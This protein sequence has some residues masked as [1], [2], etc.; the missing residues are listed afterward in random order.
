MSK[1]SYSKHD[2]RHYFDSVK[3]LKKSA[4]AAAYTTSRTPLAPFSSPRAK[5]PR[6]Y[7]FTDS[8]KYDFSGLTHAHADVHAGSHPA[9]SSA[10]DP[11]RYE[12][13]FARCKDFFGLTTT[14]GHDVHSDT[15][16]GPLP[17]PVFTT[18]LAMDDDTSD[19]S[20]KCLFPL[21]VA[22]DNSPEDG[23]GSG[24]IFDSTF[25][26]MVEEEIVFE[27]Q[28]SD[29]DLAV[30]HYFAILHS[31]WVPLCFSQ[32]KS[33]P[34]CFPPTNHVCVHCPRSLRWVIALIYKLLLVAWDLWQYKID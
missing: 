5:I 24:N 26:T 32:Q 8:Y 4:E 11:V 6:R 17:A 10:Y 31:L 16:A 22:F 13:A 2:I 27:P 25:H 7:P 20:S 21:E 29:D 23:I 19:T 14:H 15:H 12:A 34:V 3:H 9:N 18:S 30:L 33:S 28:A 1:A